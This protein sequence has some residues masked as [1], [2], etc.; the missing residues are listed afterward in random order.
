ME[1]H[2][3]FV[4]ADDLEAQDCRILIDFYSYLV[5]G[6]MAVRYTRPPPSGTPHSRRGRSRYDTDRGT[7]TSGSLC[8]RPVRS[9]PD[10]QACNRFP[11]IS[12]VCYNAARFLRGPECPPLPCLPHPRTS[13]YRCDIAPARTRRWSHTWV[14]RSFSRARLIPWQHAQR[15]REHA[16]KPWP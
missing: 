14:Y 4:R 7:S 12:R 15:P 5:P 9:H 13:T 11:D 6:D 16:G 3:Y 10:S 8:P 2:V 1:R